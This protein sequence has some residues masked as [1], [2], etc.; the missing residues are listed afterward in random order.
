MCLRALPQ[1]GPT[2]G[3]AIPAPREERGEDLDPVQDLLL[4]TFHSEPLS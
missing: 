2:V 1:P 3:L 4:S